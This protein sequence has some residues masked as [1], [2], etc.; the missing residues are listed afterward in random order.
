M[1]ENLEHKIKNEKYHKSIRY[2]SHFLKGE[3]R[4]TYCGTLEYMAP[5]ML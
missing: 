2:F 1:I 5:E 3:K 4:K